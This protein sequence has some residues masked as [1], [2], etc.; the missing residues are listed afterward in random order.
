MQ[1]LAVLL[2]AGIWAIASH[3]Q[4]Q[5]ITVNVGSVAGPTWRADNVT[6]TYLS[7]SELRLDVAT[8][9]WAGRP[10]A[11]NLQAHCSMR[12][13]PT[14]LHC[15]RG[16]FSATIPGWGQLHGALEGAFGNAESW[17]ARLEVPH[18]GLVATLAQSA[19]DMNVSVRMR[20]QKAEDL[21]KLAAAFGQAVPGEFAGEA[22]LT[23]GATLGPAASTATLEISTRSLAYQEPS[24]RYAAENLA[25]HG[26]ARW[27]SG[28]QRWA[29]QAQGRGG[30]MYAEPLFLDFTALPLKVDVVALD[31]KN[32]WR[33][34]RLHVVQGTAGTLDATGLISKTGFKLESAELA[35]DAPALAPLFATDVQPFLI[36]TPLDGLTAEGAARG[37]VSL[38]SGSPTSLTAEVSGVA[39]NA[40]RLGLSVDDLSG[41]VHWAGAS[42]APSSLQWS[43]GSIGRVPFGPST[44]SFRVQ[45]R[46]LELLAPWRQP[47][48]EGAVHVERLALSNIGLAQMDADFRGELEPIDLAALCRALDWPVFGGTLGGRLPGLR[49]RNE[50]WS[51]D[52]ALQAQ[53]FDGTIRLENLRAIEPFG[54]LPRV[55]ADAHLRRIDLEALTG[56]FSFGRITGRLDGD[57]KALQLLDWKPVAFDARFYSTPGDHSR[58]R[59]S[60]RAIDNISAIGGGPTGLLSRGFLSFFKDFSYDRMG[61]SC[62]LRDGRCQMD[63]VEPAPPQD[64]QAGYYLVKGRLLPRIDVVGYAREVSWDTLVQQVEAAL[65]S[66]GPQTR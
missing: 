18:R 64:G 23:L 39:L 63:G 36:G 38:R 53:V 25:A 32:H 15:E 24:G 6:L 51:I 37:T 5:E 22:D 43:A 27:D 59:I 19:A 12:F 8:V 14:E 7:P 47:L 62:V 34:E 17:R 31:S 45:G 9:Q 58:R 20:G 29:L 40:V 21:R 30:Q 55:A 56:T 3:A 1:K 65:A 26:L 11:T 49:V 42:P 2:S 33:I 54:V 52:G 48:L 66:S 60:Q 35:F 41:Q 4:A 50:V 28:S 13:A 10:A 16:R 61:I 57:V 44:V 46:D